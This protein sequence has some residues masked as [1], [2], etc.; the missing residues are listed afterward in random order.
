MDNTFSNIPFE[1]S[2]GGNSTGAMGFFDCLDEKK[3]KFFRG[4]DRNHRC[5]Q[6]AFL[7]KKA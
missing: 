7:W 2:V 4:L 6:R 1:Q 3:A 5:R